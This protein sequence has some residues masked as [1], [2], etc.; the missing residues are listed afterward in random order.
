M[1]VPVVSLRGAVHA[2]RVGA[3]LLTSVGHPEWIADSPESYA[4]IA[5]ALGRDARAVASLRSTLRPEMERS[6]LRDESAHTRAMEQAYAMLWQSP[7]AV[8]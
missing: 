8:R 2:A 4:S 6:S 7:S 3:S 1:G 5:L